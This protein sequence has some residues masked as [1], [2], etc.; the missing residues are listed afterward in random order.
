MFI[1]FP[2]L[3][4]GVDFEATDEDYLKSVK[5]TVGDDSIPVEILGSRNGLSTKSSLSI[6][7]M[8][9]CE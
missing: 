3:G 4:T 5:E 7:R 1:Y 8:A 6:I 2:A 9:T